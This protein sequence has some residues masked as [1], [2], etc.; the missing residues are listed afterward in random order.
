M[1]TVWRLTLDILPDY[2]TSYAFFRDEVMQKLMKRFGLLSYVCTTINRDLPMA[3]FKKEDAAKEGFYCEFDIDPEF[4]IEKV[5][6]LYVESDFDGAYGLG[7]VVFDI[8]KEACERWMKNGSKI[9]VSSWEDAGGE[10]TYVK[11]ESNNDQD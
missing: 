3:R 2:E 6:R 5:T 10:L 7:Q 11:G 8:F 9:V 1:G 4:N